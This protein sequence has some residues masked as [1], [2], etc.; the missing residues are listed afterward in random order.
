MVSLATLF[1]LFASIAHAGQ[2]CGAEG[3]W[4]SGFIPDKWP[5]AEAR[6]YF[7]LLLGKVDTVHVNKA[8]KRHDDCYGKIGANKN[9][10]DKQFLNNM[11]SECDRVYDSISELPILKACHLAANGYY[12][13]VDKKGDTAFNNAQ[14]SKRKMATPT[15]A[16]HLGVKISTGINSY[17][18]K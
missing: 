11:I 8:C 4:R 5:P 9:E 3:D 12:D 13:V 2:H 10:C 6:N 16:K 15:Q 7:K 18:K 17:V 1:L 14:K